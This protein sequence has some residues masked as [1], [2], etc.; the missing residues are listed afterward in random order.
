MKNY[1]ELYTN[2]L[3]SDLLEKRFCMSTNLFYDFPT[4]GEDDKYKTYF[5]TPEQIKLCVPNPC[6]WGAGM[7]DGCIDG[8][9][10]LDAAVICYEQEK[11]PVMSDV[12]KRIFEGL[13]LCA[14]VSGEEGFLARNVSPI[15]MKSYYIDSSRDQYTHWIYGASRYYESG[16]IS[17][18]DKAF[19][20]K[21]LCSFA[22]RAAKKRK[23]GKR[24][25]VSSRGRR[26]LYSKHYVG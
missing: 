3:W 13:K 1:T 26:S 16:M 25:G 7:E 5:P 9:A 4:F 21:A 17:D 2:K 15:D 23:R 6:G 24:V 8:G 22:S 10:M 20:K 14:S 18:E 11:N 19:V 12:A